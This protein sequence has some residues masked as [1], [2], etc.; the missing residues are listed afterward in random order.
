MGIVLNHPTH[1]TLSD[2]IPSLEDMEAITV[3][4]GGPVATDRLYFLHSLGDIIPGASEVA[5]G[6]WIGGEF[7]AMLGY[8]RSGYPIEGKLRFF[9]GYSGWDRHQLAGE[10]K[11]KVWAVTE[12][13]STAN[14]L[15]GDGDAYWHRSVRALGDRFRGWRFHPQNPHAN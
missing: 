9:I 12:I 5:P 13:P 8:I 2:L 6:L 3:Y 10:L 1:H 7:E 11:D 15:E 14:M 4:C